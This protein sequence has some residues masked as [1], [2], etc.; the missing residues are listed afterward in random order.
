MKAILV[1]TV[2]EVNTMS[3]D[4]LTPLSLFNLTNEIQYNQMLLLGHLCCFP[5]HLTK[6]WH[7]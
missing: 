4:P 7:I 6:L 5:L 1:L 3:M 2:F